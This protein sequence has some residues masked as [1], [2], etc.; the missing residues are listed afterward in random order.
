MLLLWKKCKTSR[1]R[2]T[3]DSFYSFGTTSRVRDNG[4]KIFSFLF[5]HVHLLIIHF[6]SYSLLIFLNH[7]LELKTDT[8]TH[9]FINANAGCPVALSVYWGSLFFD[10][11]RV[12]TEPVIFCHSPNHK[13]KTLCLTSFQQVSFVL[14]IKFHSICLLT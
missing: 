12:W 1:G 13:Q 3:T 2:F 9:T 7:C 8:H 10:V 11:W 5:F 4:K 14:N 6:F